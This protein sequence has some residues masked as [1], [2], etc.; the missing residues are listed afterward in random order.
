MSVSGARANQNAVRSSKASVM[1]AAAL[2]YLSGAMETEAEPVA[3]DQPTTEQAPTPAPQQ[4]APQQ[5][6]S[7]AAPAQTEQKSDTLP[8][9]SVHASRPR[10]PAAVRAAP[11]RP[12]AAPPPPAQP[13]ATDQAGSG[14]TNPPLGPTPYQVTNT[15]ITRLPVPILNMPQ[16]VNVIPQAII[17][18]QNVTTVEQALQYIPGITFSAGEGGQQ[19]DGRSSAASS[20]A[21]IYSATVSEIQAGIRATRSRSTASR[22]T[23]ARRRSRSGGGRPAAPSITS[24]G[25]RPVRSTSSRPRR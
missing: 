7:G 1:T 16:T 5:T 15:G 3:S 18:E 10:A 13:V 14:G 25:C 23:R 9:V 20:R 24:P 2:F 21:A 17:Q 19:G 12:V 22:S 8:T 4:T 11:S 6:P